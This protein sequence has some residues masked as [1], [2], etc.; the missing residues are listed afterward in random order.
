MTALV[1]PGRSI[2][3]LL[4]HSTFT[5][6]NQ[7]KNMKRRTMLAGVLTA[8]TV[9]A[10]GCTTTGNPSGGT[11]MSKR[12]SINSSSQAALSRLYANT[13]GS[14]EL[15]AKA[16][17]VLVFPSVVAAG[18]GVGGEYGEGE[19]LVGGVPAGYY[20][21]AS[22]SLG[23]QIGAQDKAMMFLFMTEDSLRR[24]QSSAG[25]TAGADAT[26]AV[27]KVGAN[28]DIDTATATAPVIG[29]VV[30]NAGLMA[31]ATIQGTKVSKLNI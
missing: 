8:M 15:V 26:V 25:W 11:S 28:G 27:L 7:E 17:G 14:H 10:A 2:P 12:E 16:R 23:L 18:L 24:F 20:S 13:R 29:F 4:R 30:T 9:F 1:S 31:G 6:E 19:L 3:V 22:A 21:T 5:L